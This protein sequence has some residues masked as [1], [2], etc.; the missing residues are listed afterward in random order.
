MMEQ[1]RRELIDHVGILLANLQYRWY[2]A[3]CLVRL[4]GREVVVR[5]DG[6]K[7]WRAATG[8]KAFSCSNRFFE[9]V[10][11]LVEKGQAFI[12]RSV[13]RRGRKNSLK[14]L[15][16]LC[17]LSLRVI[18]FSESAQGGHIVR[19]QRQYS[20]VQCF[21]LRDALLKYSHLSHPIQSL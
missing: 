4:V 15:D 17:C 21:R 19:R 12:R 14:A 6:Q 2:E 7:S 18:Q 3:P 10:R 8:G 9:L 11:L 1:S 13:T 5:Q 16:R 20:A